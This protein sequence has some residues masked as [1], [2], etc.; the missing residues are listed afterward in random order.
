M[1]KPE[2]IC[3]KRQSRLIWQAWAKAH[4]MMNSWYSTA[5]AV[6]LA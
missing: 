3:T 4:V 5:A 6:E 1:R 2:F